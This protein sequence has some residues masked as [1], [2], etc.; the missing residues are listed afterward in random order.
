MLVA[1]VGDH[2][3]TIDVV[4]EPL[5]GQV[6]DVLERSMNFRLG[7]VH[8][9]DTAWHVKADSAALA[10]GGDGLKCD[11]VHRLDG[12]FRVSNRAISINS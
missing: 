3:D 7:S 4:P 2:V 10:E 8:R 1:D 6:V 12:R 11:L 5:V 9:L